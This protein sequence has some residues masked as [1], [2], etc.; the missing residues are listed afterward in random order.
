MHSDNIL[1]VDDEQRVLAS[2]TRTLLEED[3][4]AVR[5]AQNGLD[6]LEIVRSTPNLALI[7]SDHHMPGLS[8][9]DFLVQ[10]RKITPYTTR[11]L[12]SGA[13]DLEMAVDAVNRGSIFRFL[14][15][16][17][18]TEI[19]VG[20]VKDGVR[21]FQMLTGERDLMSKTLNGSIKL[22]V[23]L[24][25]VFNP[26]V[27]NQASRL[28]IL[29]RTLASAMNLEEQSWEI[30]LAAL[31]SQIGAVALP[32]NVVEKWQNNE[33]L[34]QP[35]EE[36]IRSIPQMGKRLIKNIPRLDRIA[37][38]VGFQDL[39]YTGRIMPDI[40][41]GIKIPLPARILKI[42]MDYDR[43][44]QK[45][46]NEVAAFQ[47]LNQREKDYDPEIL[48]VFQ[49]KVLKEISM[50]VNVQPGEKQIFV[51]EV[52]IGMIVMRDVIDKQGLIVMPKGTAITEVL[53]MQLDNYS[54]TFAIGDTIY[55][56]ENFY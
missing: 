56:D 51:R 2:I 18:P 44:L 39:P 28:R 8:G 11:I 19:L 17:C 34:D 46:N 33:K 16:P 31:L 29:A 42:I 36:M 37:D 26:G 24:L 21:Q 9:I 40:P 41:T 23:D 1:I 20:S 53:K 5:T 13:A 7:I 47:M 49:N 30:E 22:M 54:R 55:I 15:K 32:K 45:S 27:F 6:A 48:E 35:D 38:A 50:R 3:F 4:D 52:K 25:S 43:F 10:A 12:L 14:I